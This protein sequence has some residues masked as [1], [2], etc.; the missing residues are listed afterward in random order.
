MQLLYPAHIICTS[1]INEYLKSDIVLHALL[2]IIILSTVQTVTTIP[3][4]LYDSESFFFFYFTC[5]TLA[6]KTNHTLKQTNHAHLHMHVSLTGENPVI[7]LKLWKY[8]FYWIL[9]LLPPLTCSHYIENRR[10]GQITLDCLL[11]TCS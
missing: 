7:H 5:T 9:E 10:V 4:V 2:I 8:K 11:P 1:Q 6:S 3:H